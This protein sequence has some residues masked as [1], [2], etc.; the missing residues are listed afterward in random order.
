VAKPIKLLEG[1]GNGGNVALIWSTAMLW[2]NDH[3][4]ILVWSTGVYGK[5]R[6]SAQLLILACLTRVSSLVVLSMSVGTSFFR[7]VTIHAF[8][9][10]TD[11]QTGQRDGK[12]GLGNTVCCII[13]SCTV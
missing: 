7:F 10:Q 1:I 5:H 2:T 11:R 13:C 9:K 6:F 8:D 4:F 12:K 3:H